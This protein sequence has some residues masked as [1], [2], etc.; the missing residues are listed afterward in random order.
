[1][2]SLY[3]VCEGE[4]NT[5]PRTNTSFAQ[6]L[7]NS[8][9][10]GQFRIARS[11]EQLP[12][13]T[14]AIMGWRR[15][16]IK[17]GFVHLHEVSVFLKTRFLWFLPILLVDDQVLTRLRRSGSSEKLQ[18][19]PAEVDYT[20]LLDDEDVAYEKCTELIR[21]PFQMRHTMTRRR[22]CRHKQPLASDVR[23]VV[24]KGDIVP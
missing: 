10:L 3:P 2:A 19:W 15:A 17:N 11:N 7:C 18:K 9:D 20:K 12:S 14:V 1:V 22:T 23:P 21:D 8:H 4:I 5:P 6:H 13:D 24:L 16:D